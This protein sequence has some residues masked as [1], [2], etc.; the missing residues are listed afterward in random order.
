MAVRPVTSVNFSVNTRNDI[1]FSGRKDENRKHSSNIR[2]TVVA[3]PLATLIAMSPLNTQSANRANLDVEAA[4]RTELVINAPS[5]EPQVIS[6]KNFHLGAGQELIFN[7]LSTDGNPDNF[8]KIQIKWKQPISKA[9][10]ETFEMTELS[11]LNYSVVGDDGNSANGKVSLYEMLTKGLDGRFQGRN[12]TFSLNDSMAAYLKSLLNSPK[13]NTDVVQKTYTNKL[14]PTSENQLQNVPNGNIIKN[15]PAYKC[16]LKNV[17]QQDFEGCYGTYTFRYYTFDENEDNMELLTITPP[18]GTELVCMGAYTN[19][20]LFSD[21][22]G[23]H[24]EIKYET[25]KL[26]DNNDKKYMICDEDISAWLYHITQTSA[27]NGGYE[28]KNLPPV[29]YTILSKGVVAPIERVDEDVND[30]NLPEELKVLDGLW[31]F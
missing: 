14:R 19:T 22:R 25:I 28:I 17:G 1:A 13:N 27:F 8:E 10:H 18:G 23:G 26:M 24:K 11:K 5:Q 20:A 16:A 7:A 12:M 30:S 6:S 21:G 4:E 3:V 9:K 31:L 2:S 15:A 29:E